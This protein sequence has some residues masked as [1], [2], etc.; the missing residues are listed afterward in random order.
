MK[1]NVMQ[2]AAN[3]QLVKV[4]YTLKEKLILAYATISFYSVM[5]FAEAPTWLLFLIVANFGI[6]GLLTNKID[7]PVKLDK[8]G[9]I[10]NEEV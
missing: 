7:W 5:I 4:K 10:I 1:T 9:N 3:G 8:D 2:R 6:S